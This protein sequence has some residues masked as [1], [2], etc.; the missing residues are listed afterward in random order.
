MDAQNNLNSLE[1]VQFHHANHTHNIP[2]DPFAVEN[3]LMY[4]PEVLNNCNEDN[5]GA[6]L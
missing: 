5:Q 2:G 4:L 6:T 1:Y 3:D